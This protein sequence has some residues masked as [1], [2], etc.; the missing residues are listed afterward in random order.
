MEI[1]KLPFEGLTLESYEQINKER[2]IFHFTNGDTYSMYHEQDCCEEVE[3]EEIIGDLDDLIGNSM[4]LAE[5]RIQDNSGD[6]PKATEFRGEPDSYTWTFYELRTYNAS[7]TLR[8]LGTS[9][10][11]YSEKVTVEK[12]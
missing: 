12:L 1:N 3:I 2:I 10:G 6:K 4:L 11:W 5:E 8:W 7:V 9:N